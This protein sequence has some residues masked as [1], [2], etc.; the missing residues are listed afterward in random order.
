M[1]L[2][3]GKLVPLVARSC[4]SNQLGQGEFVPSVL[5]FARYSRMETVIVATNLSDDNQRIYIDLSNL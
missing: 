4:S 3:Y 1:V 5:S 2:R